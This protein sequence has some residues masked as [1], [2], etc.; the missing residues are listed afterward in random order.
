[1]N[2]FLRKFLIPFLSAVLAVNIIYFGLTFIA[3]KKAESIAHIGFSN[4]DVFENEAE[5]FFEAEELFEEELHFTEFRSSYHYDTL[6]ADKQKIYRAYEFALEKGFTNILIDNQLVGEEKELFDILMLFALDSPVF[7]QNLRYGY[8]EFTCGVPV[9]VGPIDISTTLDGYYINVKNFDASFLPKKQEAIE[10][11]KEIV[12]TL[13]EDISDIDKAEQLFIYMRKNTEYLLYDD[14]EDEELPVHNYLYD[15][16]ITGKTHCD[17][18]SNGYSLLLRTAGIENVEKHFSPDEDSD[19]VGHTWN[20]FKIDDKWYNADT[21]A[22]S[23][24]NKESSLKSGIYFAFDDELLQ[25]SVDF[26]NIAPRCESYYVKIDYRTEN[27]DASNISALLCSSFKDRNPSWAAVMIDEVITEKQ[28]K[29][30][31]QKCADRLQRTITW[32]CIETKDGKSAF[33]IFEKG[34]W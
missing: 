15:A 9:K 23:L 32:M 1:M 13:P 7:E 14:T 10:K 17:G 12:A 24:P 16:L 34:L 30:L 4:G 22:D 19:K 2:K 25:Y 8:G 6:D 11:A 21:T 33:F 18:F 28:G 26:E 29:A 27:Y 20:A 5:L 31:S 3:D